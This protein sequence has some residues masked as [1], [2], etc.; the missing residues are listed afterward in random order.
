MFDDIQ[1]DVRQF[2]IQLCV[3]RGERPKE[4]SLLHALAVMDDVPPGCAEILV[5]LVRR[6]WHQQQEER[7]T[8]NDVCSG[9]KE[10]ISLLS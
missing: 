9:L 8:I 7:P 2:N 5:G 4:E 10:A 6:C 1:K 3:L